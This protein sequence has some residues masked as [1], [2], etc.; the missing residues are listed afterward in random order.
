MLKKIT[1]S[2]SLASFLLVSCG[3][4][5]PKKPHINTSEVESDSSSILNVKP[6]STEKTHE[7]GVDETQ[8]I[9][10]LNNSQENP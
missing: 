3:S 1:Y 7:G 2:L 5:E 8:K 9:F 10:K 6:L 4:V